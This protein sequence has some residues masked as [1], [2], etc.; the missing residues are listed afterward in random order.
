MCA[1]P[2]TSGMTAGMPFTEVVSA[3]RTVNRVPIRLS[4]AMVSPMFSS[5]FAW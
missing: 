5:P 3:T 1:V 4:M 2:D